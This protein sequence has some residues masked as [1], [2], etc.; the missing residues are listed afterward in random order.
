[1]KEILEIKES[2]KER[3]VILAHHYQSQDIVD[4]ADHTGDSLE[5]ARKIPNLDVEYIIFCGVHFMAE[6]A[7]VLASKGQKV[8]LPDH[9]AGCVMA[10]TAPAYLVEIVLNKLSQKGRKVIP[11]AYVNSS[12]EVKAICGKYDGSVCTSA[13]AK[14]MLSWALKQKDGVLF[15]PDRFLG[16][17]TA[18]KLGLSDKEVMVL[19]ITNKGNNIDFNKTKDKIL[20]LWPGVCAVHFRY[21]PEEILAIK[22]RYPDSLCVVHPECSPEVVRLADADGSTSFIIK[23][24]KDAPKGS[25]IFIGTEENLVKRLAKTHKDKKISSIKPSFCSNMAKITV[26]KLKSTLN[27][28]NSDR[29]VVEVDENIK[30]FAKMA[31]E[32]MLEVSK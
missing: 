21:K 11:L 17:N 16:K 6:T 9:S 10:Q 5:L 18:K 26:E 25:T 3:L 20:F 8:F 28:L 27:F 1:M 22:N 29:Y 13:N 30:G 2:L 19:D 14:I 15:I 4:F 12:A 24:V 32:T 23:Y 7:S 31:I